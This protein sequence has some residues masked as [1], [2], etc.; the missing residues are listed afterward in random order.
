[1]RASSRQSAEQ[2]NRGR[3]CVATS[4]VAGIFGKLMLMIALA[5]FT[6]RTELT[7]GGE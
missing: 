5:T 3:I 4:R 6:V 2:S 1:V 7:I